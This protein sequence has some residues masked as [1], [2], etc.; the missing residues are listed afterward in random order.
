MNVAITRARH[1]LFLFG[2]S[3]TLRHDANW[4]GLLDYCKSL[5]GN[6]F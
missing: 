6:H 2:N 4:A 5:G 3:A 1:C